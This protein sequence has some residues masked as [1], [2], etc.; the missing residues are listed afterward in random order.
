L[1][2]DAGQDL[3]G[4]KHKEARV[5]CLE[6][7]LD[8]SPGNRSRDSRALAGTKRVDVDG[9]LVLIVLAPIDK[10]ASGTE[11]L[12]LF[13]DDEIRMAFLE[14]LRKALGDDFGLDIGD[15]GVER[16]VELEAF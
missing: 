14:E 1:L 5:P 15:L 7:L 6:T 13:V 9:R 8:L 11:L 12:E 16:H 10:D 2:G 4:V 3:I